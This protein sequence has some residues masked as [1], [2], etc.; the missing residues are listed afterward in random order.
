MAD[1]RDVKD[2]ISDKL[3]GTHGIHGVGMRRNANAIS[4]A[5]SRELPQT[6]ELQIRKLVADDLDG[7]DLVVVVE[8]SASLRRS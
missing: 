2:R 3:L 1:L 6:E 4:I 7:A 5:V 8:G